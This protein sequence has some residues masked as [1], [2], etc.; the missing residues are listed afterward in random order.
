MQVSLPMD[1]KLALLLQTYNGLKLTPQELQR[2]LLVA[3]DGLNAADWLAQL[4]LGPVATDFLRRR[5]WC[6]FALDVLEQSQRQ[7]IRWTYMLQDDYPQNWL[8]LS[9][10]PILFNYM[11]PPVWCERQLLA[12]VG[13]RTPMVDT[14]LWLQRELPVFLKLLQVGVVSGGARGVDQLAHRLAVAAK[15]PTVC[16]FPSGLLNKYPSMKEDLWESVVQGGGA[17]VSAFPL[18]EPMRKSAFHL[19]NRWI[20]GLSPLTFVAEANRRSGSALTAK[21]AND[22][23]RTVCTLPV[24]ANTTQGLGNLDLLLN[25]AVLLRDA[26]D[27]QVAW[28]RSVSSTLYEWCSA[29]NSNTEHSPATN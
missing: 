29:Q 10:A 18:F 16:I 27:L 15:V 13:S 21:F 7:G 19:R 26:K 23:S 3:T 5:D 14:S 24:S 28:Q 17:L 12:V 22:E 2:V 9:R 11:G 4:R 1:L 25:G 20:A 6:A 8:S